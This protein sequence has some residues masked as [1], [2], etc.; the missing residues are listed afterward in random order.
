[1]QPPENWQAFDNMDFNEVIAMTSTISQVISGESD[2]QNEPIDRV[3]DDMLSAIRRH[4]GMDVAFVSEFKEG[5]RFFRQ[6]NSG[7]PDPPITVNDSDPL[8]DSYCQ[9]VVDG[10]LPELIC[11]AATIPCAQELPATSALPVGAHMSVPIVLSNGDIHGTF[12]SFSYSPDDTLRNRDLALMRIFSE[13]VAKRIDQDIEYKNIK[14]KIEN[15]INAVLSDDSLSMVYQP[16]YRVL[17]HKIVGFE[18]LAR[19]NTEPMRTPDIWFNEAASVDLSIPLEVRAIKLAIQNIERFSDDV[20]LAVNI[21]P[22]AII[23]GCL[24]T[25]F[26]SFPVDRIL[27]EITEHAVI[28]R[29]RDVNEKLRALRQRGMRIAVDDAG[30]GYSSLK[31]IL[32]LGPNVIKLDQSITR[33]IDSDSSR[34]SLAAA[35][36]GFANDTGSKIVAEG[37]ETAAELSTLQKLGVDNA[38]GYL[39]GRPSG[40]EVAGNL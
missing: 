4:L 35:F 14:Q 13:L 20:Y 39:L 29:Y 8:E 16:I 28:E 2:L 22:D 38:Q 3:M 36:I 6:I 23:S 26:E 40:I 33:D 37:V 21:S 17:D 19:F 15:R 12:C 25:V 34:R 11:N 10:R 30:A 27:L 5:R 1:M 31:H 24:D 9:R 18:S 7:D 32:N